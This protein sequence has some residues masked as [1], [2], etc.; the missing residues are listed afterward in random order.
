MAVFTWE[1]MKKTGEIVKGNIEAQ[2][3]SAVV[4]LLRQQDI[5]P[6]NVKEKKAVFD[7]SK[8][9]LF[10][11]KVKGKELAVFTRQF[12]TMIDAGLPLVQC[13]EI[14][15]SQQ[16]NKTFQKTIK[17][18]KAS[19]EGGSTFAA[20]LKKHPDIF[21][22]LYT[23]LV[24]A[25]EVGGMLD[26]ILARLATYIEKAENL[27]GKVKGAMI[28]PIVVLT[29]AAGAVAILL[30]F[31]I[32]IFAKMFA[33]VGAALPAPTQ[34][35]LDLSNFLKH[36]I[37][38]IIIGIA[39]I[40]FAVRSYYRT[41]NGRLVIDGLMLKLPVFGDIIRKNA[42]ARFTRTLSTMLS[43]GVPVM[44]GLEIVARTSGNQIIENAI[45]KARESIAAGKTI[46]EP[47]AQTKVF[48]SM[49][50]QMISVGEATGNMDAMLSK[51]ADFYDEEV[52]AAVAAMTSLI[53][54]LLIV[55]LGGVIGGLVVAMYL[56]IF[57]IA[58]TIH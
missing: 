17:D 15:G 12:A 13:L 36:Y 21:D 32:P 34:F 38:Y 53:E 9:N 24:S 18:V 51:I 6:I 11:E 45:M 26:T 47:L 54:P 27:K 42:V 58:S 46:S 29:V 16:Q 40:Y 50:V 43:S 3:E 55:F 7:I 1:G 41:A 28:Y 5:R 22:S 39:A 57:K 19:V 35:V 2:N 31:V 4:A 10:K 48:P 25:G 52:D 23:N 33:D 56:P 44:D 49:V 37:I 20:A 30:L 8:F 14:L